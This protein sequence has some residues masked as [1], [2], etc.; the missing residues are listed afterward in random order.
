MKEFLTETEQFN[1]TGIV[2]EYF[3]GLNYL[4]DHSNNPKILLFLGSNIGNFN[5]GQAAGFMRRA[6]R[7][8]NANDWMLLGADLKRSNSQSN[9][10][11][12]FSKKRC[13][14]MI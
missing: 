12:I 14:R 5:R 2:A 9:Q 6:W 3:H 7:V 10:K 8:L 1:I 13:Q 11:T 4:R